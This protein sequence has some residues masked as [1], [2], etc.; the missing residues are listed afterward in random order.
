M[1]VLS[2][3]LV[4]M[5][6]LACLFTSRV[7]AEQVRLS[8][9]LVSRA[10]AKITRASKLQ[11]DTF[12]KLSP[13]TKEYYREDSYLQFPGGKRKRIRIGRVPRSRVGP[14]RYTV[15]FRNLRAGRSSWSGN[16]QTFKF[17]SRR[18]GLPISC[19]LNIAAVIPTAE[20]CPAAQDNITMVPHEE[21]RQALNG[22]STPWIS[23]AGSHP[24]RGRIAGA[25]LEVYWSTKLKLGTAGLSVTNVP[26]HVAFP[27]NI[28]FNSAAMNGVR[29]EFTSRIRSR[30]KA[31]LRKRLRAF[32]ASTSSRRAML[33]E[34]NR[35]I[36]S[37]REGNLGRSGDGRPVVDDIREQG[38]DYV[39]SVR[40]EGGVT[41][42]PMEPSDAPSASSSPENEPRWTIE[43]EG[44][45][46][47]PPA[48]PST[49]PSAPSSPES[50]P[51]QT[52][53][54]EGR[55]TLP[56]VEPSAV[57]SASSSS[58]NEPQRTVEGKNRA[59]LPPVAPPAVPSASSSPELPRESPGCLSNH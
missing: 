15:Y 44:R 23:C 58:G 25:K 2:T 49:V 52:M 17:S 38:E 37:R 36:S 10:A 48:A 18:Q 21:E 11:L 8:K 50:E 14:R 29:K 27:F 54:E 26:V 59:T 43:E 42:P 12:G 16:K 1:R 39:I 5:L 7:C 46:T 41:L 35:L 31:Q 13:R 4:L 33:K 6:M 51:Q 22:G 19:A 34:V 9:R 45:N 40:E 56:P 55:V 30:V 28:K 57:P 24:Y 53:E 47:L 20:P 3:A 32:Y